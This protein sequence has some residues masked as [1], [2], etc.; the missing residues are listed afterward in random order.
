MSGSAKIFWSIYSVLAIGD[1]WLSTYRDGKNEMI[2]N[3]QDKKSSL[4]DLEAAKYGS[5]KNMIS[6]FLKSTIFPVYFLSNFIPSL[7]VLFN[8][9]E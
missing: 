1:F 8:A 4:S 2:S 7:I 6:N 3:R 5:K 9:K